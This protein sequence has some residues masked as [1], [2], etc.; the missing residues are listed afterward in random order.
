MA[1]AA[2]T[3]NEGNELPLLRQSSTRNVSLGRL[4]PAPYFRISVV[5]ELKAPA[6]S[7][8]YASMRPEGASSIHPITQVPAT[9]A[10]AGAASR[11]L[12]R[13]LPLRTGDLPA[14]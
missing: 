2:D 7:I 13:S 4:R 9:R 6:S 11:V 12:L 10:A 8:R 5:I 3:C 1:N 14:K